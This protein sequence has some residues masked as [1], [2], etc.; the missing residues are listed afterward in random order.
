LEHEN[1]DPFSLQKLSET[2]KNAQKPN[3]FPEASEKPPRS[4]QKGPEA[5][6]KLPCPPERSR[7]FP[8]KPLKV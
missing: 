1:L 2:L 7:S 4:L 3:N 8:L 5:S 6:Q